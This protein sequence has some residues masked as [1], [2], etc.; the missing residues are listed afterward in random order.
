MVDV[1]INHSGYMSWDHAKNDY[2]YTDIFPF[3][4]K[5]H[6]HKQCSIKDWTN[7]W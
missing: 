1:V 2:K 4:K 7:K 5:E 6:Y 3:D